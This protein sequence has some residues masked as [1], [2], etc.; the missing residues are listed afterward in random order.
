[1]RNRARFATSDQNMQ[2][3]ILP[4]KIVSESDYRILKMS[5]RILKAVSRGAQVCLFLIKDLCLDDIPRSSRATRERWANV[6]LADSNVTFACGASFLCS[7]VQTPTHNGDVV[8]GTPGV[9]LSIPI[10][11]TIKSLYN[12]LTFKMS[13]Y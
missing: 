5:L 4:K 13:Q 11:I 7:N 1:M 9:E 8:D 3:I 12:S 6:G 10:I 2:I